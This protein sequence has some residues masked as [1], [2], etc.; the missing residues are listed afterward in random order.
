[1]K[2][3]SAFSIVNM[4]KDG[5]LSKIIAV[6]LTGQINQVLPVVMQRYKKNFH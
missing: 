2:H 4:V 3:S 5:L 1:M 6:A